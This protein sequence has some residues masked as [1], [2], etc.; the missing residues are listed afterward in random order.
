MRASTRIRIRSPYQDIG[1]PAAVHKRV[2]SQILRRGASDPFD[3]GW[4]I[5]AR[6]SAAFADPHIPCHRGQA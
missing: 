2:A 1:T 4:D 3:S 6:G 5:R